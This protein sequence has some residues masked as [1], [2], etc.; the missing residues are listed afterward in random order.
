MGDLLRWLGGEYTNSVQ[1]MTEYKQDVT[2]YHSI[3][4]IPNHPPLDC[5]QLLAVQDDGV[6]LQ[7]RFECKR[8]DMLAR[9]KYDNHPP[10]QHFLN[11]VHDAFASEEASSFHIH[12]PRFLARFIYGL[13]L[14]PISW[15]IRKGKGRLIINAS[16]NLNKPSD[17]ADTGAPNSHIPKLWHSRSRRRVPTHLLWQRL[18]AT[19]TTHLEPPHRPPR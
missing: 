18:N 5:D 8:S 9:L 10:L 13:F 3:P 2:K 19:L 12:F 7:G 11:D 14:S 16:S 6:P 17:D 1:D 15:V 4:S